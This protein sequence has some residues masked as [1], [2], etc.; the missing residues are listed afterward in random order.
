MQYIIKYNLDYNN[1]LNKHLIII[2]IIIHN[3]YLI[4]LKCFHLIFNLD[5][6]GV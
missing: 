3:N 1:H 4:N 2:I 6:V 5:S